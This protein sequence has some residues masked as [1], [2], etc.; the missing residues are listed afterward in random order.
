[1]KINK[2]MNL[3]IL[4]WIYL[5]VYPI[6][7]S[8]TRVL[9]YTVYSVLTILFFGFL[10]LFNTNKVKTLSKKFVYL[11]SVIIILYSVSFIYHSEFDRIIYEFIEVYL[12]IALL[13]FVFKFFNKE[14]IEYAISLLVFTSFIIC[15]FGILEFFTSFNIFSIIENMRYEN[16]RFGSIQDT[17]LGVVRVEQSFNT[18]LTYA[19]YISMTFVLTFYK[20]FVKKN[21]IYI[22]IMIAQTI[23]V[24]LTMTRGV[25]LIFIAGICMLV[26]VN[27]KYLGIR[28]IFSILAFTILLMSIALFAFPDLW[29]TINKLLGSALNLVFGGHTDIDN[30]KLMRQRYQDNAFRALRSDLV[31]IF[32]VGEYGLRNLVSI[33]NEW[34]LEIT[35]YGI[36]G[37]IA[38]CMILLVPLK[39]AHNGLKNSKMINDIE[40]EFFFCCML[41]MLLEYYISLYTVAQMAEAKMFY[42]IFAIIISYSKITRRELNFGINRNTKL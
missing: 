24:F 40:S 6:L 32:G 4:I 2:N 17:R 35:G 41:V 1:M 3:K 8:Y 23:N 34:L 10:F 9:G 38:F 28:R 33:D 26:F 14:D 37:F 22:I 12:P 19:I 30:S 7:P 25:S 31:I 15:I 29:D 21:K 20:Y 16:P 39:C 36:F 27:R 18:P 42:V 5:I 11:S 13:L